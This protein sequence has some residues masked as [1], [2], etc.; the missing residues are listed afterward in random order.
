MSDQLMKLAGILKINPLTIKATL[1][2]WAAYLGLVA[3]ILFA[4]YYKGR[5]DA[6]ASCDADKYKARAEV[7]ERRAEVAEESAQRLA[8]F[9]YTEA[10]IE[11][12]IANA[13]TEVHRYYA[14][15]PVQPRVVKVS[16]LIQ[17]P[18]E[19]EFVYVP[20]GVCPNDLF[21]PDEL[22]LFNSGNTHDPK[23]VPSKM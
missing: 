23:T 16:E 15:N 13:K 2:K 12:A 7:A 18:G 11:I 20:E 1:I 19:K 17:V 3:V 22:R 4:A 6:N 5:Q 10:Q 8:G 14:E 21:N 9:A